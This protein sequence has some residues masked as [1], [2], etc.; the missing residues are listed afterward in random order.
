MM[1]TRAEWQRYIEGR[2]KDEIPFLAYWHPQ[3][4]ALMYTGLID[5]AKPKLRAKKSTVTAMRKTMAKLHKK[6]WGTVTAEFD[7]ENLL[8]SEE[9]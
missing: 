4:F 3:G 9:A 1:L 5:P 8:F 2:A 6:T 7:G